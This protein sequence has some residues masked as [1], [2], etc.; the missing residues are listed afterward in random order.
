MTIHKMKTRL[1]IL[2]RTTRLTTAAV[3]VSS[4]SLFALGSPAGAVGVASVPKAPVN[5]FVDVEAPD[6]LDVH[7]TDAST[8][9]GQFRL[10]RK[11]H[12]SGNTWT[13][14]GIPLAD[15][16]SGQP[17]ATGWRIYRTNVPYDQTIRWCYR[18]FTTN[19]DGRS[20][21]SNEQCQPF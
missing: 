6:H 20:R 19:A 18:A 14:V 9:E 2:R 1:P 13:E 10:E 11:R 8:N 17:R 5:F 15:H 21:G 16:R 3:V 7:F 4:M 12:G